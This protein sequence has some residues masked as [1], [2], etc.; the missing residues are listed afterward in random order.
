M[1]T[2]FKPSSSVMSNYV[3]KYVRE[4]MRASINRRRDEQKQHRE[5]LAIIGSDSFIFAKTYP[6]GHFYSPLPNYEEIM[7]ERRSTR[8]KN[9]ARLPGINI[10]SMWAKS[11][12]WTIF[13]S[14]Y[15]QFKIPEQ[16]TP[17]FRFF[18]DSE[19]FSFGDKHHSV[20]VLT[21]LPSKKSY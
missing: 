21:S 14:Y 20:F 11:S 7:N 8:S 10:E 16:Q 2:P 17:G 1:K 13:S 18:L 4:L 12:S 3:T 9:V 19:Y 5:L 15:S 6:P